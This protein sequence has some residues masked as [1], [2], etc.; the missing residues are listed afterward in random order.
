MS[1]FDRLSSKETFTGMYAERFARPGHTEEDTDYNLH[2][3]HQ[4]RSNLH[5][6]RTRIGDVKRKASTHHVLR[7]EES[8][9]L[10]HRDNKPPPDDYEG[11]LKYMFEY[12]C[13]Y[14][15]GAT[16]SNI[17]LGPLNY[18]RFCRECPGLMQKPCPLS[19]TDLDLIYTKARNKHDRKLKFGNFL[20]AL[21]AISV[22]KFP[23]MDQKRAFTML[24]AKH[25]LQNPLLTGKL[26]KTGSSSSPMKT[27]SSSPTRKTSPSRSS[28]APAPRSSTKKRS[29]ASSSRRGS[30]MRS[31]PSSSSNGTSKMNNGSRPSTI[32]SQATR[33]VN[34]PLN[35]GVRIGG[36]SIKTL[37]IGIFIDLCCPHSKMLFQT[38]FQQV[39]PRLLQQGKD[40]AF[41]MYHCPQTWSASLAV[42][43]VALAVREVAPQKYIDFCMMIFQVQEKFSA[44]ATYDLSRCQIHA[45]A[46]GFA[47]GLGVNRS[48]LLMKLGLNRN[49][50]ENRVSSSIRS[51]CLLALQNGIRATPTTTVNGLVDYVIFHDWGFQEWIRYLSPLLM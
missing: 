7:S 45:I 25:V 44:I 36:R 11:K 13:A 26:G 51:S 4:F 20:D 1:V 49:T 39:Y 33:V 31:S 14:A 3:D 35:V 19:R 38:V 46:A 10:R 8:R 40:I 6:G 42:N 43:E 41:I 16:E 50:G 12:Y 9:K 17:E 32:N 47:S 37:E 48:Q 23:R 2:P 30:P 21:T 18:I 15:Q 5:H 34:A 28:P 24:L 27:S 29:P 22:K